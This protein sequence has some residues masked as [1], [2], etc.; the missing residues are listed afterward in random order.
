MRC[1]FR[2]HIQLQKRCSHTN[3][4]V[5]FRTTRKE[6]GDDCV[7]EA[8][9]KLKLVTENQQQYVVPVSVPPTLPTECSV[10]VSANNSSTVAMPTLCKNNIFGSVIINANTSGTSCSVNAGGEAA[11]T[12]SDDAVLQKHLQSHK[13]TIKKKI[14]C[15]FE[16]KKDVKNKIHL[17]KVYTQVFITEGELKEVNNEH[18]ILKIDKAFNMKKSQDTPINCN[19]IF[20]LPWKNEKNK[21]VLTKGVAGIGKTVSVQKFIL[22]WAEGDANQDIDCMFLLPFREI[23]LVKDGEYSFHELLLEFYPE[24]DKLKETKIYEDYKLAFIFDGLDESRLPLDFNSKIVC[25]VTKKASVDALITNLVKG[26]I[27]PSTQIWI[28]SRPAAAHHIPSEHVSLFTEVRGFTDAQ[29]EEYFK[30]RILDE[31]KASKIIYHIKTSRSLYIMCHIPV[32]CWITATVLQAMLVENHGEDIP[33]TLTEMYIHFLLIQMNIKNQKYDMKYERDMKKLMESNREM[34]LKLA[35]LAFEQLKKKNIMFYENDLRESG[36]DV[37][38]DSEFSGICTEIFKQ[39]S[40][41]HEEKVYCFIHLSVQEFLA[42]LHVFCCYLN[43]NFDELQFFFDDYPPRPASVKLD[44]LLKKAVDRAK[45]NER[46]HLDLF[47]RFLLGISL[48]SSQKFLNGLLPHTEKTKKSI[49]KVIQHIRQMQNKTVPVL[50]PETSIN[51]FFCLLEL[52]ERSHYNQIKKYLNMEAFPERELSSSNCSALAYMLLMS[53]EVLDEFDPKKYNTSSAACRRLVPVVRCCRKALFAGCELTESCCE[54]VSVALQAD[55]SPLRELDLSDNYSIGGGVKQLSDGLKSS[56]CKLEILRL[57]Q[58]HFTQNS[59]TELVSALGSISSFLKELDLSGN[60]LE[61]SGLKQ[62]L[63]GFQNSYCKL[64]TLRLGWCNLT[65]KSSALLSSILHC[66]SD[67]PLRVLDLSNND[68][69]DTGVKMLSA[70]LENPNCRLEILGLSGCSITEEGCSSLASALTSNPSHLKELDLTYN[71][72]G[73]SGVK[74]LSA[75]LQDQ[76]CKLLL[77]T[78]PKG[79]KFIKAG[80]KKYARVLTFDPNTAHQNLYLSDANRKVTNMNKNQQHP[81]HPDRFE[82]FSH[83]LCKDSQ[84]DRCYWEVD[85]KDA[86]CIIG[87]TYEEIQRKEFEI[88]LCDPKAQFDSNPVSWCLRCIS[89]GYEVCHDSV[90]IKIHAPDSKSSR[91]GVY[92]DWPAGKLSFY[93]I[94]SDTQILNHIHTFQAAFQ[95]PLYPAFTVHT[96][97]VSLCQMN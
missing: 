43:K 88:S 21:L 39:E 57:A 40:V 10:T 23:N 11:D 60:D 90:Y 86:D 50:S 42:A 22:D 91:I 56:H 89:T 6:N 58:C 35:K 80:L 96:G 46:G 1:K 4:S 83:V 63:A 9:R 77:K 78:D 28:T 19:Q 41:L 92:L 51:N 49:D 55:N 66:G 69:Q 87:V 17:K 18:E 2:T 26:N 54:V 48:E 33:T 82:M 70:G 59:C 81:Y 73:E 16:G 67:H 5:R 85:F 74:L 97:S 7:F 32:F 27:L 24:L 15:I 76:Q 29:K 12:I 34:I 84:S 95:K 31:N 47:L 44:L 38:E 65:E 13:A 37:T 20:N 25:S 79:E 45:Q 72:P 71:H 53:E 30:K 8:D 64:N 14:E 61:D 93:S 62:L 52:K 75:R 3:G 94:S 68:L 36:I